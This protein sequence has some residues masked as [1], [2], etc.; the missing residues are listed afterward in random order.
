M[1]H[2]PVLLPAAAYFAERYRFIA[3]DLRGHGR[4]EKVLRGHTVPIQTRDLRELIEALGLDDVVLVGWSSGA[5]CVW[6]YLKQYGDDGIAGIVI[7]DEA[8]ADLNRDGWTLGAMDIDGL[9]AMLDVVQTDHAAMVRGRFVHRLFPTTPAPEDLEWMIDEITMIPPVVAAAVAFDEI[10]RDYREALPNVRVPAL[11][12]HGANDQML[13]PDN[14]PYLV[15]AMANARLV[16]F[17]GSGH[18]PFWDEAERFNAEVDT[19]IT[20]L[21]KVPTHGGGDTQRAV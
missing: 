16:M 2:E 14:G 17:A 5:F 13:S 19:F 3:P 4:S 15:D 8:A 12:C 11:V 21:R 7:V 20:G 18:A 6:E 10:T 1:A 9:I